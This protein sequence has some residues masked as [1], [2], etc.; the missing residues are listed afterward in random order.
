VAE[1][2][3][4]HNMPSFYCPNFAKIANKSEKKVVLHFLNCHAI[5][6]E[7][8]HININGFASNRKNPYIWF[9]TTKDG[10]LT[11]L[12]NPD[13]GYMLQESGADYRVYNKKDDS[14]RF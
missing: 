3:D 10:L 7:Q 1:Y 5:Q 6:S 14:I 4:S 13:S 8:L 12:V 11:H 9:Y 2:I